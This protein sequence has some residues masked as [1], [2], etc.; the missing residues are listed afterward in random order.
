MRTCRNGNA[1]R[2]NK[3]PLYPR[4]VCA[5]LG[6]I[7]YEEE[8]FWSTTITITSALVGRGGREYIMILDAAVG[9]TM[10]DI[11]VAVVI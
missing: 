3:F 10:V 9:H 11:D 2:R 6:V 7:T 4:I 1:T 8:H 5:L